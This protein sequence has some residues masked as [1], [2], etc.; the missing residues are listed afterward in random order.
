MSPEFVSV[1]EDKKSFGNLIVTTKNNNGYTK[2]KEKG[3]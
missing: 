3:T 2:D 1:G